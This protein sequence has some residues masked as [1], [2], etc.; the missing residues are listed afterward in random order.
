M[1]MS[2][3]TCIVNIAPVNREK[4]LDMWRMKLGFAKQK[5]EKKNLKTLLSTIIV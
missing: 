5:D 4:F 3:D 1:N 2:S